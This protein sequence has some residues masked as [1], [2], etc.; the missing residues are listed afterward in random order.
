ML[1]KWQKKEKPVFTGISRG[2]GGF[3][4]GAVVLGAETEESTGEVY[5][6]ANVITGLS[7]ASQGA[8]ASAANVNQDNG[9][10]ASW[11]ALAS[12]DEVATG[13]PFSGTEFTRYVSWYKGC[14]ERCSK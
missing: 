12:S 4:F 2:V 3:G 1:D 11:T 6:F 9:T 8:V 7:K 10:H 5:D 14:V 13:V